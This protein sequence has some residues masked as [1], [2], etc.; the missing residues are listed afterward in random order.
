MAPSERFMPPMSTTIAWPRA[1]NTFWDAAR[2]TL[3]WLNGVKKLSVVVENTTNSTTDRE[4]L[5]NEFAQLQEEIT[6]TAATTKF[7]GQAILTG[8]DTAETRRRARTVMR[9]VYSLLVLLGALFLWVAFSSTPVQPRIAVQAGIFVA[10][11]GCG[12]LVTRART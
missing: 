7:N 2:Q 8:A 4:A 5:Q 11:G 6:R 10:L 3:N 12:L 1:M 9:G